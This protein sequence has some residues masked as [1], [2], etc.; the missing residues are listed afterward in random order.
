MGGSDF[1]KTSVLT[2]RR[3]GA[4]VYCMVFIYPV[5]NTNTEEV[6]WLR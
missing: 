3:K 2:M 5:N 4:K 6:A 1:M